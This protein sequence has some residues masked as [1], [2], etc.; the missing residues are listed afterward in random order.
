[1]MSEGLL[2][3]EAVDV[4]Q[5]T[6]RH[7]ALNTQNAV[8]WSALPDTYQASLRSG[9]RQPCLRIDSATHDGYPWMKD[10]VA[11]N[12]VA[13]QPCDRGDSSLTS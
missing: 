11:S 5:G 2:R 8:L 4:F 7:R 6:L 1:M 12:A 3:I 13:V 9:S 10:P